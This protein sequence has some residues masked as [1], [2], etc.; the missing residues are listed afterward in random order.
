M[1]NLFLFFP[2]SIVGGAR[3]RLRHR[4]KHN[5]EAREIKKLL[6][7]F[8]FQCLDDTNL[9]IYQSEKI[10]IDTSSFVF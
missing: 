10:I 6:V 3:R 4:E 7:I 5:R 2:G 1:R 9:L 8:T